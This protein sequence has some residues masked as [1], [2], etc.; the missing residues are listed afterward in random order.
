MDICSNQTN[1]TWHIYPIHYV[2][3]VES[4]QESERLNNNQTAL[5]EIY[6]EA[7]LLVPIQQRHRYINGIPLADYLHR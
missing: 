7:M 2:D 6:C 4:S 3:S 5:S 1:Q